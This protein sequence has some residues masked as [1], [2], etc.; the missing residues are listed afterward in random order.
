[1][2]GFVSGLEKIT[3]VGFHVDASCVSIPTGRPIV[4]LAYS[5]TKHCIDSNYVKFIGPRATP[6]TG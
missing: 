6:K 5:T 1:M 3:S 2:L 4:K